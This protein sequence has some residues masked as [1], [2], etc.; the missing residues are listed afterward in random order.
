MAQLYPQHQQRGQSRL[1]CLLEQARN[2]V[3]HWD[4]WFCELL[5]TCRVHCCT[6]ALLQV[7]ISDMPCAGCNAPSLLQPVTTMLPCINAIPQPHNADLKQPKAAMAVSPD[8]P[9][10]TASQACSHVQ[11]VNLLYTNGKRLLMHCRAS[12]QVAFFV[13]CA[14]CS[15]EAS[16]PASRCLR[17]CLSPSWKTGLV[18]G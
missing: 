7:D 1:S 18:L 9:S 17:C 12:T 2:E 16:S 8:V 10:S 6:A 13:S 14:A 15:R 5:D 4:N 3:R 11:G